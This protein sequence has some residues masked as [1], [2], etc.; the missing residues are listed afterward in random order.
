MFFQC[1]AI[2]IFSDKSWQVFKHPAYYSPAGVQPNFRLAETNVGFD[3]RKDIDWINAK[4]MSWEKAINIAEPSAAPWYNLIKR[5]IPFWKNFGLKNFI[6]QQ[7]RQ[8]NKDTFVCTLPYN[9]QVTPYFKINALTGLK[10]EIRTDNYLVAGKKSLAS[11]RTKYITK[12]GV[13]SFKCTN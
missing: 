10:I 5:P 12:A 13:Q 2:G 8:G 9:A 4:A 7:I 3:A 11:V 6:S 1:N